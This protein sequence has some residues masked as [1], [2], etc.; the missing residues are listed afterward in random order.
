MIFASRSLA[1]AIVSLTVIGPLRPISAHAGGITVY[2]QT[3]LMNFSGP[4]GAFPAGGLVRDGQGNLFG[5]TYQGGA[6]DN[7]TVFRVSPDGQLTTLFSFNRFAGGGYPVGDLIADSRGNLYGTTTAGGT[8]FGGT[9]Y[10]LTPDG[11]MT[12]LANLDS[13]TGWYPGA[14]LVMD[15]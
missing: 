10:K 3:V 4:D 6:Y 15:R 1:T 9:V 2:P 11:Q 12:V 13:N 8:Y 5:T 7:G 14:G